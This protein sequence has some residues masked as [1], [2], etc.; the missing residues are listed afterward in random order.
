MQRG[1]VAIARRSGQPI[2][3]RLALSM[4]AISGPYAFIAPA[5]AYCLMKVYVDVSL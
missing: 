1:A 2:A 3:A 4:G 5:A